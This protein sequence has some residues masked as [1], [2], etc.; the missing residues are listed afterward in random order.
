MCRSKAEGGQR[1]FSHALAAYEKARERNTLG[2][3]LKG[4]HDSRDEQAAAEYARGDHGDHAAVRAQALNWIPNNDRGD[5]LHDA[6]I[7]LASTEQGRAQVDQWRSQTEGA[8]R[9]S[10]EAMWGKNP[11]AIDQYLTRVQEQGV[12]LREKN[13]AVR[14]LVDAPTMAT[15]FQARAQVLAR[16]FSTQWQNYAKIVGPGAMLLLN[17]ARAD[18]WAAGIQ[19]GAGALALGFAAYSAFNDTRNATSKQ[20][21]LLEQGFAEQY[22]IAEQRELTTVNNVHAKDEQ[23]GRL[24]PTQG[25]YQRVL[26]QVKKSL[27]A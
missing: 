11:A 2:H 18:G 20:A 8:D 4:Y 5:S 25:G 22:S 21:R 7:A 6:R 24:R 15:R 16:A 19:L 9:D 12:A 3:G 14:K 27:A 13:E 1:C 23:D 26:R 10:L 17:G